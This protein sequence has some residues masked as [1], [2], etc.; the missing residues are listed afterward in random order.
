MATVVS[1][2]CSD[3]GS[4]TY[5]FKVGGH[6][7]TN[8]SYWVK[9]PCHAIKRGDT[10][11]VYYDPVVPSTNTTMSPAEALRHYRYKA[12]FPFIAATFFV[13]LGAVQFVRKFRRNA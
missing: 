10:V 12:A 3:S 8:V 6:T 5:S 13:I 7:Y 2:D 9:R 11:L 1:T 4:V